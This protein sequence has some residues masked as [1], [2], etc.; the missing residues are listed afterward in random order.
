MAAYRRP[1]IARGQRAVEPSFRVRTLGGEGR[2]LSREVERSGAPLAVLRLA[3]ESD[4]GAGQ[5]LDEYEFTAL[6]WRRCATGAQ[7]TMP[8]SWAANMCR[9]PAVR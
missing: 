6:R 7:P 1:V 9:T 4:Q 3:L 5:D 2:A 8:S